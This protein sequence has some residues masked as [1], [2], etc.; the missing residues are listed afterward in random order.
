MSK[1][2][3]DREIR[4]KYSELHYR[5]LGDDN[6]QTDYDA[7]AE[8]VND[9]MLIDFKG[10]RSSPTKFLSNTTR[11]NIASSRLGNEYYL[12]IQLTEDYKTKQAFKVFDT[13]SYVKLSDLELKEELS[14][15]DT[16][17]ICEDVVYEHWKPTRTL[18]TYNMGRPFNEHELKVKEYLENDIGINV[19]K[20]DDWFIGVLMHRLGI[21]VRLEIFNENLLD[22]F[23]WHYKI[24][25]QDYIIKDDTDDE[26]LEML[27]NCNFLL[28]EED[29]IVVRIMEKE[30][31]DKHSNGVPQSTETALHNA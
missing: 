17:R 24:N 27:Y 18:V 29:D 9:K 23:P 12:I 6:G 3:K 31:E 11:Y 7:I 28:N 15:Y 21:S 8:H 5:E 30:N 4:N 22:E 26:M 13:G 16:V 25:G 1:Y 20:P 2:I 10:H 14:K 19:K